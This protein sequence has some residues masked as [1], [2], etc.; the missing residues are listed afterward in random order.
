[1]GR[2]VIVQHETLDA[3][4]LVLR[5]RNSD[6]KTTFQASMETRSRLT[7]IAGRV[8]QNREFQLRL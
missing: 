3:R 5:L 1:M 7:E 4:T 6:A 8:A 2:V